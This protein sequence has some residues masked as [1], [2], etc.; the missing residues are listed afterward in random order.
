MIT[1]DHI[2]PEEEL[3]YRKDNKCILSNFV[4]FKDCTYFEESDVDGSY[5]VYDR[6]IR[7]F[8]RSRMA[9]AGMN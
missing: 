6:K 9:S 5:L 3:S 7:V 1:S 8:I 2:V 4:R